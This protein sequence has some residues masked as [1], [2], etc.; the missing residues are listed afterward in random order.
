MKGECHLHKIWK[1]FVSIKEVYGSKLQN[2]VALEWILVEP[3]I[4]SYDHLNWDFTRETYCFLFSQYVFIN[5]L[6]MPLTPHCSNFCNRKLC[7][8]ESKA[9]LISKSNAAISLFC[10]FS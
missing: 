7:E 4:P 9:F 1:G 10:M 5:E 2:K 8:T 6:A 3:V